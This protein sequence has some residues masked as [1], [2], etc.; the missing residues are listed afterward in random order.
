[1]LAILFSDITDLVFIQQL[2]I[3]LYKIDCVIKQKEPNPGEG[4]IAKNPAMIL[5][6]IGK[7][8]KIKRT[9]ALHAVLGTGESL[10]HI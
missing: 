6:F 8:G 10:F 3:L 1:V 2:S 4:R 9:N 7:N 5:L